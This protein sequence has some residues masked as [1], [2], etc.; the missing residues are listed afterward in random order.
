[1]VLRNSGLVPIYNLDAVG[2]KD[3][4]IRFWGQRSNIKVTVRPIIVK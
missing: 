4:V 1:V 3:E 2:D